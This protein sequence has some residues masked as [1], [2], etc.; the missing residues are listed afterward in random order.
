MEVEQSFLYKPA[1]ILN[2]TIKLEETLT[3]EVF[4]DNFRTE[5]MKN[6]IT[7]PLLFSILLIF[8]K[9]IAFSY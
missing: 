6:E 1:R 4:V 2:I 5:H 8:S 3:N 7:A 9:G